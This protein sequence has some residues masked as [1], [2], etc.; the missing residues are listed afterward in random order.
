MISF[1]LEDIAYEP[2]CMALIFDSGKIVLPGA[3]TIEQARLFMYKLCE[4]LS[5]Q[6]GI[7]NLHIERFHIQNIVVCANVGFGLDLLS[8]YLMTEGVQYD[9]ES[10]SPVRFKHDPETKETVLMFPTG[11]LVFVGFNDK[12]R[13]INAASQA[14]ILADKH[15]Q[16]TVQPPT[17]AESKYQ[18]RNMALSNADVFLEYS[19]LDKSNVDD[20]IAKICFVDQI[21]DQTVKYG[22]LKS[23]MQLSTKGSMA[24]V[25][26]KQYL[27]DGL[28]TMMGISENIQKIENN[29]RSSNSDVIVSK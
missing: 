16:K 28:T 13:I 6:T 17:A 3:K 12:S 10:Y 29:K 22:D 24:S 15:K 26:K 1:K 9:P 7:H 14:Y 19:R 8:L 11:N 21:D 5:K 27:L 20:T 18:S 25:D 4:Y 23:M 2:K